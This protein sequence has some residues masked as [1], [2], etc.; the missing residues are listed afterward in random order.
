VASGNQL[1]PLLST[2]LRQFQLLDAM[3]SAMDLSGKSAGAAVAG[4]KPPVF[5]SRR[6]TVETALTRWSRPAITA[7]LDRLQAAVLKSRE[8]SELAQPIIRQCFM[9]LAMESARSARAR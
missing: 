1:F 9:A 2:A 8:R 5:F 3:R 7:A 6:N 4:A